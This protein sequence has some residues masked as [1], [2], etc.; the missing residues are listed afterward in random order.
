MTFSLQRRLNLNRAA[1]QFAA[2]SG[3]TPTEDNDNPFVEVDR[4][5]YTVGAFVSDPGSAAVNTPQGGLFNLR[6][7]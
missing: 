3:F 1:P 5:A 2:G 4:M 7:E 6:L